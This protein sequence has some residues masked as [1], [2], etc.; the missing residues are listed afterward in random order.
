MLFKREGIYGI[1]KVLIREQLQAMC[2]LEETIGKSWMS[3]F[4]SSVS[5]DVTHHLFISSE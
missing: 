5:L 3:S 1:S 4:Y 2:L